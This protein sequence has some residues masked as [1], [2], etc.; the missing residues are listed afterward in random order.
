MPDESWRRLKGAWQELQRVY[1]QVPGS[2]ITDDMPGLLAF[3]VWWCDRLMVVGILYV[4]IQ[5]FP[6]C[7]YY[8]IDWQPMADN[9]SAHVYLA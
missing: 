4:T 7:L 9:F 5:P 8:L 6:E 1:E 3:L 2:C